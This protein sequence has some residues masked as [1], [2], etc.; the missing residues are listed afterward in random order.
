MIFFV[1]LAVLVED[2]VQV[3]CLVVSVVPAE[4]GGTPA[5]HSSIEDSHYDTFYSSCKKAR[6]DWMV[7]STTTVPKDLPR[8][9]ISGIR[10][11]PPA[12]TPLSQANGDSAY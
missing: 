9:F 1:A 5:H 8:G 10:Q 4:V 11:S 3:C 12:Q 6:H 7:I 2:H